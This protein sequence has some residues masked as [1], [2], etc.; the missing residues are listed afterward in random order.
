VPH[1][2]MDAC[3]LRRF[4]GL[5]WPGVEQSNTRMEEARSSDREQH[6]H[7]VGT[8]GTNYIDY[9]YVEKFQ[10]MECGMWTVL[11]LRRLRDWTREALGSKK[12]HVDLEEI[13][14]FGWKPYT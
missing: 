12:P 11:Y 4:G 2:R 1:A 6:V 8:T 3:M 7:T 9:S 5:C 10:R 14:I 13:N